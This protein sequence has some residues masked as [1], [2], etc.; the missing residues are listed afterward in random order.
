MFAWSLRGTR[1]PRLRTLLHRQILLQHHF[2]L[3]H[4][5]GAPLELHFPFLEHVNPI[6][7]GED[8]VEVLLGEEDGEPVLAQ[9]IDLVPGALRR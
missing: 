3:P 4:I 2:I 9:G 7:Q 1:F 5:R 8:E 6:A